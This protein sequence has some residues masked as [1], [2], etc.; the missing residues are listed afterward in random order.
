M[1][2]KSILNILNGQVMYDYFKM[3][4]LDK[5]GIYIP[6]NEAMCA[7]E[8]TSDIFSSQFNTCRSNTHN[9]TMDKYDEIT[10]RPLQVLFE[11]KFSHIVLWFDNDMFCQINLLTLLAYLDQIKYSN[12]VTF[13]L[14]DYKY[15]ISNQLELCV[16]GYHAIYEQVMINKFIPGNLQLSVMKNGIRL[17]FEYLRDEN[18]ITSF[19]RQNISLKDEVLLI[20]LLEEFPQYGLGDTQYLQLIDKCRKSKE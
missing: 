20:R 11:N 10:L 2:D 15:K 14:V 8:V 18:E 16:K 6:F 13:N 4:G 5:N 7:G 12:N 1:N 3:H 9:V 19:V 17:Y